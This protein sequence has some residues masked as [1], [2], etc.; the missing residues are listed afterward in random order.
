[1][2]QQ[3]AEDSFLATTNFRMRI[4]G[5]L[6]LMVCRIFVCSTAMTF[7]TL[8]ALSVSDH[9]HAILPDHASSTVCSLVTSSLAKFV[10]IC[11]KQHSD[12]LQ[13]TGQ[14]REHGR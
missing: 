3:V 11:Q 7:L 2:G 10:W 8:A 5:L 4:L 14:R 1:M 13:T 6:C 9:L 12:Q